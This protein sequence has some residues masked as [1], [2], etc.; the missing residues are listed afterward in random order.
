MNIYWYISA[1]ITL[2]TTIGIIKKKL[3]DTPVPGSV[4]NTILEDTC[5][6][7]R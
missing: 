6:L 7:Q 2:E 5:Y 1:Q 3:L 4:N